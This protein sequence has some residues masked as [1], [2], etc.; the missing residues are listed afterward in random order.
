[1]DCFVG[2]DIGGTNVRIGTVYEN[3]KLENFERK[4]SR[5]LSNPDASGHLTSE[6]RAYLERHAL[7]D[8][9]K[10][11]TIGVPSCVSKDG[12]R[13][14]TT[15]N[16][17]GLEDTDL[18]KILREALHVPVLI[19]RDVNFL[20]INDI[21]THNLDTDGDK[22]IVGM[23]LGTGFGN[24][25]YIGGDLYRGKNGVAG[26]LGHIPMYENTDICPCGNVGCTETRVSGR[27]LSH[28][29][30]VFFP[31]TSIGEL[32]LHHGDSVPLRKFV[33]DTGLIIAIEINLLDPDYVILGG[34]VFG[35]EGF[36]MEDLKSSIRK[37][38][39]RP[40]PQENIEYVIAKHTQESGV[41]GGAI[42]AKQHLL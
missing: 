22:T 16:L 42:Y 27:Y 10:G 37:R 4:S 7:T 8:R 32:F 38:L 1:M 31:E 6:I 20:L 29:R 15:P 18:G 12:S 11:I 14:Y 5:Y 40:Y 30:D 9:V 25:I 34:G 23:Y 35:M 13:I 2:V 3:R 17:E 36:P 24:A 41:L 26:E 21:A 19:D 28:L 33:D 39:R